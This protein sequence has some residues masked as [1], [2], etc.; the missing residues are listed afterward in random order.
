[1]AHR[2]SDTLYAYSDGSLPESQRAGVDAHLAVCAECRHSLQ[3][4]QRLDLVLKDFPPVPTVP[5][6]RFWSK[7]EARLPN[8]AE[9]RSEFFRPRQLAAGFALAV[10]ASLV[11]AVALASDQTMPDSPLYSVKHVRQDLEL[12][13]TSGRERPRFELTLGK[14]RL[15]EAAV[16][17]QRRR[18]DLAVASLRDV[19]ALLVDAAPRLENSSGGQPDA[20]AL[21]TT[22]AELETE[23]DAVRDADVPQDGTGAADDAAV[24][25]A[26]QDAQNAVTEVETGVDQTGPGGIE[27]PSPEASPSISDSVSPAPSAAPSEAPSP[28]DAVGSPAA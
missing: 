21:K 18:P 25:S 22:V 4:I 16:M 12:S 1:M 13:L 5:F 3:E 9:K 8:H 6:P 14:Q 19:R 23:L 7:L 26:V 20:A 24:D 17:L 11:G 27:S 10:L 2:S 28:T 15:R